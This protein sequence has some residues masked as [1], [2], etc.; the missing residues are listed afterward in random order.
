MSN[1]LSR[2]AEIQEYIA[3]RHRHGIGVEEHYKKYGLQGL[4]EKEYE[5]ALVICKRIACSTF[6]PGKK[7]QKLSVG[8]KTGSSQDSIVS[9]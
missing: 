4:E 8:G 2:K 5:E 6:N 3:Y 1:S 9:Q 7:K